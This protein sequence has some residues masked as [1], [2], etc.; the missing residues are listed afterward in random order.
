MAV[1]VQLVQF[2]AQAALGVT[3][4]A[5][6]S[7]AAALGYVGRSLGA[8]GIVAILWLVL[9]AVLTAILFTVLREAVIGR[10][11]GLGAAWRA[12]LPKVPGLIGVTVLVGLLLTVI[13]VVGFGLAVGLGVGIGRAPGA[14]VGVLIGLAVL[15]LLIYLS[16]LLSLAAPAYV[17]EGIG[18][19]AALTRSRDLV[20]GAWLQ[21]FGVAPRRHARDQHHRRRDRG[22]RG[23][24]GGGDVASGRAACPVRGSTSRSAWSR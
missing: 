10:R 3:G 16:V 22:H 24:R 13:A 14:I 21:V 23:R 5:P 2:G 19:F 7:T 9:G 15:V 11:T 8:T 20:R 18:V 1:V 4:S 12:A 17:M 6:R